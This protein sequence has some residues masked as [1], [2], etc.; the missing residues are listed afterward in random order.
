M[1]SLEY[2]AGLLDGEGY[3]G[4]AR[5]ITTG[6]NVGERLSA[7]IT[8]VYL[9]VLQQVREQFGG[10]IIPRDT[11]GLKVYT[12]MIHTNPALAF[13]TQIE[14]FTVIKKEQIHIVFDYYKVFRSGKRRNTPYTEEENKLR[15]HYYN[16]LRR[17]KRVNYV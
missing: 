16:E 8:N 12:W 1:L 14:P 5:R 11:D 17:L 3:V 10:T 15:D 13:I 4:F 6:G 9:P 7:Q 2:V